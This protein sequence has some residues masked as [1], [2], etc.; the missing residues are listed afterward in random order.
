MKKSSFLLAAMLA[1]VI[2]TGFAPAFTS[3]AFAQQAAE[4]K[5][6]DT[7]V[8][9]EFM[10]AIPELQKLLEEK[11]YAETEEKLKTL[12]AMDKKLPYEIFMLHRFR[13]IIGS[14]TGNSEL[15][16][17]SLVGLIES[18]YLKPEERLRMTNGVAVE[19]FNAKQY[20]KAMV[21]TQRY[22]QSDPKDITVQSMVARIHY[23]KADYPAT[24]KKLDEILALNKESKVK[25]SEETLKLY[26]SCYQHQKD[27]A[28]YARILEMMAEYYPTREIWSDLIYRIQSKPGF[29]DRLRLDMYRLLISNG[30]MDDGAQYV[31]MAELA[32]LAAL[33]SE[34]KQVLEAGY[35]AGLLGTGKDA[36]KHKQLR[37]RVNKQV[38][39]E[40]KSQEADETAARNAKG[41]TGLVNTG[42]SYVIRG[43]AEKGVQLM[44]LGM[45]KGSLKYEDEARLHMGM[46][47]LKTGNRD[48]AKEVFATLKGADAA[49]LAR[50]WLLTRPAAQN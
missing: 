25:P 21:W 36:A 42:Y 29:S 38:A 49:D 39:D 4:E 24:I 40:L 44:E 50:L 2:G 14:S 33:P 7:T 13:A 1:A 18:P 46:A 8:R 45:S 20:D 3:T 48:K 32:L 15:L 22:L 19:Y 31:E 28:G 9:P 41:G 23:L 34:A 17:N 11:K 10:K 12:D 30:T 47:Y 37:D 26:T 27:M 6:L 43:Q 35:S 5:K 16:V